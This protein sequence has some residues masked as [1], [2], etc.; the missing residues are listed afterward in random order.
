MTTSSRREVAITGVGLVT[1]LGHA[2]ADVM[3]RLL[4]GESGISHVPEWGRIGIESHVA[5]L[6]TGLEDRIARDL[7]KQ[8]RPAM[9]DAAV[10]CAL[11]ALDACRDAG[12]APEHLSSGR[13]ACIVGSST[14]GVAS[15]YKTVLQVEAGQIRRV[16][17][18]NLLRHMCSSPSA[19][20]SNLLSIHGP[21]YSVGAACATSA[22]AIGL[23]DMLVRNG[24]VDV[25]VV[26][27]GD[28]VNEVIAASF[29]SLRMALSTGFNDDPTAASRPFDRDRDGLVLSGGAGIVVIESLEHALARSARVRGRIAGY[30]ATS[31]AHDMIMPDPDGEFAE[32]CMRLAMADAGLR[33][34]DIGYVN[35]HGTSTRVGDLAEARAMRRLFGDRIPPFSSTKSM[36]GHANG[37][38][39][40][41]ELIFCLGMLEAGRLAPSINVEAI[42]PELAG[43]PLVT[44]P[45]TADIRS[46]LSNSFGFG[47]TNATLVIS[48]QMTPQPLAASNGR[49]LVLP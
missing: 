19:A 7:P 42:D 10:Y 3:E 5:G 44:E 35:A 26:G 36:T 34:E 27:G 21:S 29:Q 23:G 41:Q 14:I 30:A 45:R 16:D 47:G 46:V 48:T 32:A 40:A 43:Y 22:H 38:A 37:A 49:K 31:D 13:T 12:L 39:G 18:H 6:I 17:P 11:A 24:V 33:L 9:S 2:F 25:A 20:V 15:I 4:K 1:S 28:E 8:L